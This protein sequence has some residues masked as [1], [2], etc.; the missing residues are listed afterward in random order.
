MP[1]KRF[2]RYKAKTKAAIIEAALA[3]RKTGKT[4][5]EAL[6]AG[7]QAGYRGSLGG[8]EQMVLR[9]GG[10]KPGRRG[11]PPGSKNKS[12]A[13]AGGDVSA[14]GTLIEKISVPMAETSPPGSGA[15]R[16]ATP[17]AAGTC[18][19]SESKRRGPK[20]NGCGN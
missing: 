19:D 4:W 2:K 18:S 14:I 8:L 7:Q 17:H 6:Q 9:A 5:A 1:V 20:S 15:T 13:T 3:A 12:S 10:K 16:Q 11:R